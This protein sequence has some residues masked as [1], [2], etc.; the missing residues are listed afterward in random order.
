MRTWTKLILITVLFP[1]VM[2]S[3]SNATP[4]E[5]AKAVAALDTKY[6]AAVKAN[7]RAGVKCL[8]IDC[9]AVTEPVYEKS[10]W[11]IHE[12]EVGDKDSVVM[13][14]EIDSA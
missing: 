2:A 3:K 9:L 13:L 1:L 10:G 14:R 8:F 7:A 5:D 4:E 6:Q 12:R 11:A